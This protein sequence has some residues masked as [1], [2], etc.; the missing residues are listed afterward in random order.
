MQLAVSRPEL[1]LLQEQGVV[2]QRQSVEDIEFELLRDDQGVVYEGVEA[3]LQ[4]RAVVGLQRHRGGV[5][6]E[7]GGADGRVLRVYDGGLDAVEGEEVSDFVG[8]GVLGLLVRSRL[9]CI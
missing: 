3:L 8:C 5:V 6:E 1:L 2:Q 9:L 7:V 4:L